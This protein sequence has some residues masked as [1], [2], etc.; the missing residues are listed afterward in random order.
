MLLTL[1][2]A[3]VWFV[4][5]GPPDL[6]LDLTQARLAQSGPIRL[7]GGSGGSNSPPAPVIPLKIVKAVIQSTSV[8]NADGLLEITVVNTSDVKTVLLPASLDS[9]RVEANENLGRR[10]M[11]FWIG[12]PSTARY[13]PYEMV[14][15]QNTDG[16]EAM[17]SSYLNLLPGQ[18][19]RVKIALARRDIK[20][21]TAQ[22]NKARVIITEDFLKD[23]LFMIEATSE[24]VSSSPLQCEHARLYCTT[25]D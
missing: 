16:S 5:S 1:F 10:I 8:K 15:V 24:P 23:G 20:A 7:P 9:V 11:H 6:V 2:L 3:I 22:D 18:A 12:V 14:F 13:A 21:I 17:P 25:S 4:S 19:V